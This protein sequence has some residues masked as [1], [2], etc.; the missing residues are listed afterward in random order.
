MDEDQF[1]EAVANFISNLL[2]DELRPKLGSQCR[3]CRSWRA[4]CGRLG[5]CDDKRS[6][7]FNHVL[8]ETHPAC[9]RY[10]IK[11]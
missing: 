5:A 3:H 9:H 1:S 4:E 6:F 10:V 8:L 11:P 2:L 7:H